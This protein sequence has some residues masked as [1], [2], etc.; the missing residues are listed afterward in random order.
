MV[1]QR[2]GVGPSGDI[3]DIISSWPAEEQQRAHKAIEEIEDQALQDM[4]VRTGKHEGGGW[5]G[6]G[7]ID[8]PWTFF[9]VCYLWYAVNLALPEQQLGK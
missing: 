1:L 5:K 9:G 6:G 7:G 4:Q 8:A 3:L 2:V